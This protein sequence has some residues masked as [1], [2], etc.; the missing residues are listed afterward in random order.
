MEVQS[1][2]TIRRVHYIGGVI[3]IL[4]L[5]RRVHYYTGVL[6]K[7]TNRYHRTTRPWTWQ[8]ETPGWKERTTPR[9][10]PHTPNRKR[11]PRFHPTIPYHVYWPTDS[12][13]TRPRPRHY[14][15]TGPTTMRYPIPIPDVNTIDKRFTPTYAVWRTK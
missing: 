5:N 7:H 3:S 9:R 15:T 1:S 4:Y 10:K 2:V 14:A 8:R 11:T 12:W 6:L 13:I